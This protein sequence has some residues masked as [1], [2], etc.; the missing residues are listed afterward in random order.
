MGATS[1]AIALFAGAIAP[2]RGTGTVPPNMLSTLLLV[3]FLVVVSLPH[4]LKY[5]WGEKLSLG[6]NAIALPCGASSVTLHMS[7]QGSEVR[8]SF[9]DFVRS[10]PQRMK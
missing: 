3:Y 2:S 5:E 7:Q 9:M 6:S 1:S 8:C 10:L 4:Q